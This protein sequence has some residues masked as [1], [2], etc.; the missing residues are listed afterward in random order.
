MIALL[1]AF[2]G[3]AVKSGA[4]TA[5]DPR[6]RHAPEI[7]LELRRTKDNKRRPFPKHYR[8]RFAQDDTEATQ[9][10]VP[11]CAACVTMYPPDNV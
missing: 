9:T 8:I 2:V 3:G 10:R 11:R 5:L 4:T 6:L 7:A 1:L